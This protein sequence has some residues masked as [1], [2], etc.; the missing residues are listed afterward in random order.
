MGIIIIIVAMVG[1]AAVY[2]S[3]VHT[4]EVIVHPV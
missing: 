1:G 3:V 2:K 4:H